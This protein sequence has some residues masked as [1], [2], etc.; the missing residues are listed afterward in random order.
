MTQNDFE[1]KIIKPMGYFLTKKKSYLIFII[2]FVRFRVLFVLASSTTATVDTTSNA[3]SGTT[4]AKPFLKDKRN[5]FTHGE[6]KCSTRERNRACMEWPVAQG[7]LAVFRLDE[8][9]QN[10]RFC[11]TTQSC[12]L[13][14]STCAATRQATI[15]IIIRLVITGQSP[16]QSNR[17]KIHGLFR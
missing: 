4:S 7:R 13:S 15:R 10:T 1:K 12:F 8:E 11:V 9:K 16:I 3:T 6:R 5:T 17:M 2:L 14:S